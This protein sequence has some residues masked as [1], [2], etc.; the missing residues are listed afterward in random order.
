MQRS[1]LSQNITSG[2]GNLH[3]LSQLHSM[4]TDTIMGADQAGDM[5]I[6]PSK[7]L[8][9]ELDFVTIGMFIIGINTP[10]LPD[11]SYSC[12][13]YLANPA[14]RDPLSPSPFPPLQYSW[15]RWPLFPHWLPPLPPL[16]AP[17]P[18]SI[19]AHRPRL[20]LPPAHAHHPQVPKHLLHIPPY[21]KSAYHARME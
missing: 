1:S 16:P 15:R 11:H 3:A 2:Q 19:H 17:L 10:P 4:P 13:R 18:Q 6:S 14:R 20:R 7:I 12:L 8:P 21:T 5:E 9:D